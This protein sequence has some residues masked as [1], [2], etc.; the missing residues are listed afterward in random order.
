MLP[1]EPRCLC[2]LSYQKADCSS[3]DHSEASAEALPLRGTDGGGGREGRDGGGADGVADGS[4]ETGDAA[5][6]GAALLHE[7]KWCAHRRSF[8]L[9]LYSDFYRFSF[10]HQLSVADWNAPVIVRRS[11]L[12]DG[13]DF[14]KFPFARMR[15]WASSGHHLNRFGTPAL[16]LYKHL[17]NSEGGSVPAG[18]VALLQDPLLRVSIAIDD[19]TF[20]LANSLFLGLTAAQFGVLY[21]LHRRLRAGQRTVNA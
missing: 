3:N 5:S 18:G 13:F 9:L 15:D 2:H 14:V 20:V 4:A 11:D 19:R 16:Q 12:P 21:A 1:C 8:P 6:R 10:N 17:S 7:L